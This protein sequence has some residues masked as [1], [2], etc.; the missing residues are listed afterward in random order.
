VGVNQPGLRSQHVGSERIAAK[1]AQVLCR[2]TPGVP[3]AGCNH[4]A[5]ARPDRATFRLPAWALFLPLMLLFL[6][7][8]LATVEAGWGV[9]FIVPLVALVWVVV[10]RT[11]ATGTRLSTYGLLGRRRME[12]P[13]LDQLEV[14]DSRWVVAIGN[15]GRRLRLPMVRPHDLRRLIDVSGGSFKVGDPAPE[16]HNDPPAAGRPESDVAAAGAD[17]PEA[18]LTSDTRVAEPVEPSSSPF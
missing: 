8:P 13:D 3:R 9:L 10:T 7:T 2:T 1:P 6:I 11:T 5:M 14:R 16:Q 12:W 15:D 4:G 17:S 18:A